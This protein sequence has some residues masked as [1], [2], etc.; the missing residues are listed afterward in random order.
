MTGKFTG[1][2]GS[3]GSTHPNFPALE[4]LFSILMVW[5]FKGKTGKLKDELIW[6][7][8]LGIREYEYLPRL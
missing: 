2:F 4:R 3:K 8:V 6:L 5:S 7:V 1:E